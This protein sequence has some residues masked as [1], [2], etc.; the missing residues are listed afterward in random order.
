[1]GKA[2]HKTCVLIRSCLAKEQRHTF[3]Q[4]TFVY[5]LWNAVEN[6]YMKKSKEN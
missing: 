3:L 6:K 5:S 1:M 4:E 2:Q